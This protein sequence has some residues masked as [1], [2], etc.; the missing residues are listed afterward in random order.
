MKNI[1]SRLP[2][3]PVDKTKPTSS[4]AK[5][6]QKELNFEFFGHNLDVKFNNLIIFLKT[7]KIAQRSQLMIIH[8]IFCRIFCFRKLLNQRLIGVILTVEY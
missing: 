3:I 7:L 2:I 6:F 1:K 5:C 8:N 4:S